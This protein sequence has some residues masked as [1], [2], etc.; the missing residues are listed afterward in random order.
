MK[1][2]HLLSYVCYLLGCCKLL[3][4][5]GVLFYNVFYKDSSSYMYIVVN[6]VGNLIYFNFVE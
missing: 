2:P 5:K 1:F 4:E 6:F 3:D